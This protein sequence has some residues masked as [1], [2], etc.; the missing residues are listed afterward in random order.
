[1]SDLRSTAAT[2]Q[3]TLNFRLR[4]ILKYGLLRGPA[5]RMASLTSK[6]P[7]KPV[8]ALNCNVWSVNTLLLYVKFWKMSRKMA[9][10][11]EVKRVI[12]LVPLDF[13]R[14][15]YNGLHDLE[16]DLAVRK[17]GEQVGKQ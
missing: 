16:L 12:E 2:R 15:A 9:Y 7:S 5:P 14:V 11:A 13:I 3:R 6:P 4:L 17:V 1:M 8:Q 10:F